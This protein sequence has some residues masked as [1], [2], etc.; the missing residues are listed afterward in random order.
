MERLKLI[1]D[2]VITPDGQVV[3]YNQ[4]IIRHDPEANKSPEQK[5]M[6]ANVEQFYG[7]IDPN[8]GETEE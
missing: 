7:W 2:K 8:M 1:S 6:E 3:V 4:R 5:Y